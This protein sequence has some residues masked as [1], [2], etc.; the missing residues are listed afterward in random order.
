MQR[1]PHMNCRRLDEYERSPCAAEGGRIW[2]A[3]A[4]WTNIAIAAEDTGI[5]DKTDDELCR[6]AERLLRS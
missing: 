6:I 5:T 3:G 4:W 1:M 2:D